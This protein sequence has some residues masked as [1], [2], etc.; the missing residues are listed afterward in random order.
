MRPSIRRNDVN[1]FTNWMPRFFRVCR[2]RDQQGADPRGATLK[3][4]HFYPL[5]GF[6]IPTVVIGYGIVIPNSCI[7]GIN[8]HS[9]GFGTT[10]L[11]ACVT[12]WM[13]LRNVVRDQKRRGEKDNA[14][15]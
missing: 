1:I 14:T 7:A 3:V 13:G 5:L 9:V 4:T 11:G 15:S 8:Q 6:V 2:M 10:V 12:Y